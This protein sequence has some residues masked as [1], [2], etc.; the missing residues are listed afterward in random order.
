MFQ[1]DGY[2]RAQFFNTVPPT[3]HR[4][5][6]AQMRQK[7]VDEQMMERIISYLEAASVI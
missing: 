6:Y 1:Q 2:R 3:T 7:E 4:K 5:E